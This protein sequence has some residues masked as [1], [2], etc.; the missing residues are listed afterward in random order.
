MKKK[1]ILV[2]FTLNF[3]IILIILHYYIKQKKCTSF[4]VVVVVVVVTHHRM[5]DVVEKLSFVFAEVYALRFLPC[6]IRE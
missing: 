6:F 1:N 3:L 4:F 2:D 5:P